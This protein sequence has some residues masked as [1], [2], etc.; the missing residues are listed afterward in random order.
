MGGGAEEF[1]KKWVRRERTR[2]ELGVELCAEHKGVHRARELGDFHQHSV[3]AGTG[4][5][6]TGCLKRLHVVWVNFVAMA[7]T[8]FY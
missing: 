5:H 1:G 3:G 4:E 7:M 6:E 2:L 8:F